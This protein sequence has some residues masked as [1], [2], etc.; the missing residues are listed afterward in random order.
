[1]RDWLPAGVSFLTRIITF[2]RFSPYFFFLVARFSGRCH[3]R[4]GW[5]G[6]GSLRWTT[7]QSTQSPL[8]ERPYFVSHHECFMLRFIT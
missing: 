8:G 4:V 6:T 3:D 1:M 5:I 2:S 7:F